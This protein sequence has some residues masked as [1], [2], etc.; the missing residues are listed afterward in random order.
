MS[1]ELNFKI[2]TQGSFAL[3]KTANKKQ[4]ISNGHT[5]K[6]SKKAH[7]KVSK[8]KETLDLMLYGAEQ[9]NKTPFR[10]EFRSRDKVKEVTKKPFIAYKEQIKR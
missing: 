3:I 10:H 9:W 8:D 6:K 5:R 4:D 2:S 7:R 1:D